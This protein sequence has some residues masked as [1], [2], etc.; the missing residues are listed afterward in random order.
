MQRE[1]IVIKTSRE[2]QR[3]KRVEVI[4]IWIFEVPV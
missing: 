1:R 2:I 4:F 3:D